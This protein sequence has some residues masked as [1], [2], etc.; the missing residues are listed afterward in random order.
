MLPQE[1]AGKSRSRPWKRTNRRKAE[2]SRPE[3][4]QSSRR[5][6]DREKLLSGGAV[7]IPRGGGAFLAKI[8]SAAEESCGRVC[9]DE[10][11]N[12][13]LVFVGELLLYIAP[14]TENRSHESSIPIDSCSP[15]LFPTVNKKN[16]TQTVYTEG[17]WAPPRVTEVSGS[18]SFG[19]ARSWLP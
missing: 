8:K 6:K 12:G 3:V 11:R 13:V 17:R 18:L 14:S 16:N 9:C 5:L 4:T 2:A 15:C 7:L 19:P 1:P 10:A